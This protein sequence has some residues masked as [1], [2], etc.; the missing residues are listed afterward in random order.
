MWG[1]GGETNTCHDALDERV[2]P[3]LTTLAL[4]NT[5]AASAGEPQ[6]GGAVG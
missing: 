1:V 6:Q 3:V 2:K 5:R 4:A